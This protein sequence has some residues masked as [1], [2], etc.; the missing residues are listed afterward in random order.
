METPTA[1]TTAP[2][3]DG[4]PDTTGALPTEASVVIIGAGVMGAAIAY[5]LAERGVEDIVIVERDTPGAGST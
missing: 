2:A 1:P 4:A 3:T 5:H